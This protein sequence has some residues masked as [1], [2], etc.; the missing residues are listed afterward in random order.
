MFTVNGKEVDSRELPLKLRN[1]LLYPAI[2]LGSR[3]YRVEINLGIKKFKFNIEN[4]LQKK[5]YF[6]IYDQIS[7][8]KNNNVVQTVKAKTE[9]QIS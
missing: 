5:Y 4:Y 9:H 6:N 8:F 3:D 7:K 2:S 1:K